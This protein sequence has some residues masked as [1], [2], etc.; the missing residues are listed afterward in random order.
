MDNGNNHPI[1]QPTVIK[2]DI[3]KVLQKYS[4]K[5]KALIHHRKHYSS[6]NKL[7]LVRE[8]KEQKE[9]SL[10]AFAKGKGIFANTFRTWVDTEQTIISKSANFS[11]ELFKMRQSQFPHLEKAL[12][13]WLIDVQ[14]RYPGMPINRQA[15]FKK[16]LELDSLYRISSSITL[17]PQP[18]IGEDHPT[19]DSIDESSDSTIVSDILDFE[20]NNVS[21]S[22]R[23]RNTQPTVD[24][25]DRD[26]CF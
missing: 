21:A 20:Y 23:D 3:L 12:L 16:A 19:E 9:L 14:H 25:E 15:L 2:V 5:D 26:V 22:D 10:I 4:S 8:F 13:S 7:E 1:Q 17:H 11:S 6:K 24:Y 18:F